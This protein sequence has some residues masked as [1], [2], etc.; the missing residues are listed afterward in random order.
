MNSKKI[1]AAKILKVSPGKV[2]F[3]PGAQA[4]VQKA[5]TRGD[6]RGLI[7]VHKV[8]V[9]TGNEHSRAGARKIRRQRRKG[10]H[11]GR[12]SKK[13]GQ[14][15]IVSSKDLWV[16][17]IRVQRN[18]LQ[19]LRDKELISSQTY[20]SLY[21]KSKGGFFRNKR[22]IKLYLTEYHLIQNKTGGAALATAVPS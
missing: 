11:Q 8:T 5:I 3:A 12:G 4:E 19:E 18:F 21:L 7:A 6:M 16:G 13:G 15:S 20:R 9:A 22:H 14:H 10:R 2:R 17:R 1:L